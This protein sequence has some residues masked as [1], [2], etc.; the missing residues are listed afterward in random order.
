MPLSMCTEIAVRPNDK[1]RSG[2][3]YEV[4]NGASLPNMGE[5]KCIMMTKRSRLPKKIVFQCADVH[6]PLLSTARV[7]DMGYEYVMGKHGGKLVDLQT[8][9]QIPLHRR[10]SL[11]FMKA[12]VRDDAVVNN[13]QG[14]GRPP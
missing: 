10:G 7:A 3:E 5:R 6:K 1:S 12:W 13:G 9:D 14:F 4:A 2:F 11:Y 8:G